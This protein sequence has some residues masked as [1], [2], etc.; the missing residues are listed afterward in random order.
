MTCIVGLIHDNVVYIG[1]DS[2]SSSDN[3]VSVRKDSKVFKHGDAVIGFTTSWRMGQILRY[4]MSPFAISS[5]QDAHQELVRTYVPA[6]RKVAK[7]AG[8]MQQHNSADYLG[9]FL[10][11]VAGRLFYVDSDFQVGEPM[12]PYW[13]VGSGAAYALGALAATMQTSL[14]PHARIEHAIGAAEQFSP[15]VRKPINICYT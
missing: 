1:G 7:D 11:G 12:T 13:A 2:A 15:F 9:T 10:I 8:C 5:G 3:Q 14:D 6:L 4:E